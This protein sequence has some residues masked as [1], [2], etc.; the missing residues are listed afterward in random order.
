MS[1]L[2]LNRRRFLQLAGAGAALSLVPRGLYG[3]AADA[4]PEDQ[5]DG[6]IQINF[7]ESTEVLICGSTLF[8][9]D[10]AVRAAMAGKKTTLVMDRVN[11]FFEGITCL[12][13]WVDESAAGALPPILRVVT[14]NPAVSHREN[15]RIYFNALKAAAV[16][17]DTLANAGVRFLYNASVAGALGNNGTLAGVILGGK[18]GLLAIEAGVV[19]DA[20]VEATVA[21]AVGHEFEPVAGPRKVRYVADLLNPAPPRSLAYTAKNGLSVQTDIHR[22]FIDFEMSFVSDQ[23]GPLAF[24][25]D[26]G[27]VYEAGLE[28]PLKHSEER[29][30]GADGYLHSGVDRLVMKPLPGAENLVV[31]GP[32]AIPGNREGALVLTDLMALFK[33]FPSALEKTLSSFRPVPAVRPEYEFLNRAMATEAKPDRELYH[34]FRDHGFEEPRITSRKVKFTVP[35]PTIQTTNLVVGGGTSGTPAAYT[36]ASLGLET[37]CL[38]R[39]LEMGGTNTLGWVNNL[40]YGNDTKAFKAYFRAMGAENLGLNAPGFY[41]GVAKTGCRILFQSAVT[42]IARRGKQVTR[43]YLTTPMGLASVETTYVIDATGDGSIAAWAGNAYSFGGVHD[44]MTVVASLAVTSKPR[45]HWNRLN[46]GFTFLLPCDER[47]VFDTTRF[48]VVMRNNSGKSLEQNYF[49]PPFYLATRESRHIQG[50]KTLTYLDVMSGRRFSDAVLRMESIPDIKGLGTSDAIKSGF[51]PTDWKLIIQTSLPYAS[52]IPTSLDN[53][54][55]VG[56]AYSVTHDALCVARMQRDLAAMGMVAA[57]AV[58]QSQKQKVL[59]RDI[60]ISALQKNLIEKKIMPAD[61][62]AADDYGFTLGA[63]AVAAQVAHSSNIDKTLVPSAILALLPREQAVAALNTYANTGNPAIRRLQSFLGIK[64]GVDSYVTEVSNYLSKPELTEKLFGDVSSGRMMPDQGF[65]PIPAVML[66]NLISSRQPQAVPLLINLANRL[67]IRENQLK[68]NWGYLFSL[69]C[70]FERL[71]CTEGQV[72]LKRVLAQAAFS[73]KIIGHDQEYRHCKDAVAERYT[74][75][76]M[77]LSRALLRCGD[78]QGAHELVQF[79][80]EQRVFIARAARAELCEATGQDFGFNA[81]AWNTWLKD[82]SSQIQ[83]NPLTRR[84]V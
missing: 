3:F 41:Q 60:N 63:E 27:R 49:A 11:P 77:A 65:G 76:R 74:Y 29:Q 12:R 72:P 30:R 70:G 56:K 38:E 40:W 82:H 52:L 55:V 8:A 17:E 18:M 43:V 35:A 34:G 7:A 51:F 4:I 15:G 45:D 28:C 25:H 24:T 68:S 83:I 59:L 46:Q 67:D 84:F 73:D 26:Y 20:T 16:I 79:L 36:S 33:A 1:V 50:G 19:V 2:N 64:A 22:H 71:P 75:L 61:A 21:R 47:S 48:I 32:H 37:V 13:S 44:E 10:L 78:P 6:R 53:M 54:V 57:E 66:G 58:L 31:F 62:M 39:G 5:S 42:G 9:C 23:K 69:S 80:D 81:A 14:S